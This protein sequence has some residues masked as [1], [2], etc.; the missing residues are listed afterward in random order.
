VGED[1][2]DHTPKD[3]EIRLYLGNA[4][5]IV[6]ER[7]QKNFHVVISG[8]IVDETFEIKIRNHKSEPVEVLVY[9]H[10]WRWNEWEITDSNTAWEKADQM[11]IK[12]PVKL[13]NDEEK[14]ISYTIR[15]SW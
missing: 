14:V 6:G 15:Y 4:F 8:H 9:E 12:F 2:I 7:T 1:Q 3:E 5:D 13:K 10:P 11:T